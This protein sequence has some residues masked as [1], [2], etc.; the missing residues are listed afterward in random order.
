[1]GL[2]VPTDKIFLKTVQKPWL[3]TE[4][5]E[6]V[7]FMGFVEFVRVICDMWYVICDKGS[8]GQG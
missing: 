7:E 1:M 2:R 3:K 4:F 5:I 6:F 8:R